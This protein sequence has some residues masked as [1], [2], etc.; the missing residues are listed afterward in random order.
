MFGR[1]SLFEML[2]DDFTQDPFFQDPLRHFSTFTGLPDPA[3]QMGPWSSA[4]LPQRR[5]REVATLH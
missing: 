1:G 4:A 2:T 5:G 3:Q